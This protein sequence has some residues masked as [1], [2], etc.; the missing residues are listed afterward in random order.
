[1]CKKRE[2]VS[3]LR[4]DELK[5]IPRKETYTDGAGEQNITRAA[6]GARR[7]G[8]AGF[9]RLNTA[10]RKLRTTNIIERYFVEVRRRTRPMVRFVNVQPVDRIL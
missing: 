9:L 5:P 3:W 10:W 1:M 8:V 7:T 4:P 2:G 6:T